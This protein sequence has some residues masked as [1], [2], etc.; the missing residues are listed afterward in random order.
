MG[1]DPEWRG[2]RLLRDAERALR[3]LDGLSR[4]TYA[5][6]SHHMDAVGEVGGAL[7]VVMRRR[8]ALDVAE[9]LAPEAQDQPFAL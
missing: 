4:G 1:Y 7:R 8:E 6:P 2:L 3:R 9:Q 5:Q